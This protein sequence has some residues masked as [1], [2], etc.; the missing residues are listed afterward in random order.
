M[1]VTGQSFSSGGSDYATIKY[2]NDGISLSTNGYQ[3][4]SSAIA[5]AVDNSGNVFV[6]GSSIGAGSSADY[7]TIKYAASPV[8]QISILEN[9]QVSAGQFSFELVAEPGG[10]FAVQVSTNLINWA[11]IRQ[12]VISSGGSTNIVETLAPGAGG[13]YYRAQRQ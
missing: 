9:P 4:G 1:F 8:Q 3:L 7:A 10:A 6:T 13:T 11:E 2:S 5:L 12:V